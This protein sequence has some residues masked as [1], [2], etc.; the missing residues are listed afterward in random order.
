VLETIGYDAATAA[1][2]ARWEAAD[3]TAGRVLRVDRGVCTVLT[4]QGPRRATLGGSL[5][6][7]IAADPTETPCPGDWCVV[8]CW[9]D[10]P[11]TLERVLPRRTAVPVTQPGGGRAPEPVAA[12]V[13]V[14]ALVV[15]ASEWPA[16]AGEVGD[17][18]AAVSGWGARAVL[19]VAGPEPVGE[20]DVPA[21]R[22]DP[23]DGIG[24]RALADLVAG[25]LTLAVRCLAQVH[26]HPRC[27]AAPLVSALVGAPTL[28]GPGTATPARPELVL[29]PAGGAVIDLSN[30]HPTEDTHHHAARP[31][32]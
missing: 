7:R 23:A 24:L 3:A 29:L 20:C 26:P 17:E 16:R 8:R 28:A 18:L 6:S 11:L 5:F 22:V 2:F 31:V 15:P 10:G 27:P 12:N 21:L 1:S 4:E 25:H 14:V 13:D 9:P 30:P 19:L 32:S